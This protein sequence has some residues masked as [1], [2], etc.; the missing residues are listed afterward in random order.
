MLLN[1]GTGGTGQA[2]RAPPAE[3]AGEPVHCEPSARHRHAVLT[4]LL[5]SFTPCHKEHPGNPTLG[6]SWAA[7][8]ISASVT[9][10][11]LQCFSFFVF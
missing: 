8:L 1:H 3:H 7:S 4:I 2:P 6:P 10:R 9:R 5:S 11:V